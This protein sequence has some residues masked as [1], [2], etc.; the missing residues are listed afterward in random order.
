MPNWCYTTY[1]CVGKPE[2]IKSLNNALVSIDKGKNSLIKNGFGKYWLGNLVVKLGGNCEDYR[3]RGE[4]L[5]YELSKDGTMLII[6]Q[7]TAWCE[8]EGVR[9]VIEEK[10]P[11]IKVYYQDEEPGCEHYV[12]NSHE[13]FPER[14]YLDSSEDVHEYYESLESAARDVSDIVGHKVEPDVDSINKALDDYVDSQDDEDMF[15]ALHEFE[16]VDD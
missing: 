14:Y 1:K 3:C 11:G 16:L 12:T 10:F 13:Y 9:R 8:Q 4:I 6:T 5:D 2:D 15:Y 7:Q